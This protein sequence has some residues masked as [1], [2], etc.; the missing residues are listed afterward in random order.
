MPYPILDFDTVKHVFQ[1]LFD[2]HVGRV[3]IIENAEDE[4]ICIA[5]R[6]LIGHYS[7]K[8]W[9]LDPAA[10]AAGT[11]PAQPVQA[12]VV[13]GGTDPEGLIGK[14]PGALR[15]LNA[16][17]PIVYL[18]GTAIDPATLSGS[19]ELLYS[20]DHQELSGSVQVRGSADLC[21][22]LTE[23]F[24]AEPASATLGVF[25][26]D[27]SQH[28]TQGLSLGDPLA[29]CPNA[30]FYVALASTF[31]TI[32]TDRWR[33]ALAGLFAGRKVILLPDQSGE[34]Q[35]VYDRWLRGQ[36]C[37]WQDHLEIDDYDPRALQRAMLRWF[38]AGHPNRT[39]RSARPQRVAGCRVWPV[40]DAAEIETVQG[41]RYPASYSVY[42][43]WELCDGERTVL[44]I[45]ATVIDHVPG[46][47][48]ALAADVDQGLQ[49][50]LGLKMIALAWPSPAIVGP[51]RLVPFQDAPVVIDVQARARENDTIR[52]S[53]AL[54]DPVRGPSTLWYEVPASWDHALIQRAD[55]FLLAA[56]YV[57]MV[58]KRRLIVQG[59]PVSE[60]LL[61][62]LQ[63]FQQAWCSRYPQYGVVPIDAATCSDQYDAGQPAISCYSGG[64][65]SSFTL[66]QHSTGDEG[67][68]RPL[69]AAMLAL[70]L[71]IPAQD[72][73]GFAPLV[74]MAQQR[75]QE[76]SL[77]LIIVRTNIRTTCS[78][79]QYFHAPHIASCL[80]L[81]GGAFASGLIP[82]SF[83][84]RDTVIEG[85]NPVTDPL[86]GSRSFAI[87]HHGAAYNRLEKVQRLLQWP[88]AANRIRVCWRLPR[89]QENC[90]TC[91]KCLQTAMLFRACGFDPD[92]LSHVR[93]ADIDEHVRHVWLR[94]PGLFES[95]IAAAARYDVKPPWL[96]SLKARL[97]VKASDR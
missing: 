26:R 78:H 20:I 81:F 82:S 77:P 72:R 33:F 38:V 49:F 84:Y 60:S 41:Q 44:D 51:T 37:E 15:R 24:P 19:R 57:A 4:M 40:H 11:A 10:L 2:L 92:S 88:E 62:N 13:C 52:W 58:N 56:L 86:L 69:G 5:V 22:T 3:E 87:H 16:E 64:V 63:E 70:G 12:F 17:C 29:L 39:K 28:D 18:A 9:A 76:K 75:L 53:A 61:W 66:L 89:R 30:Y 32:V 1:P 6:H 90:G 31:A 43:I 96:E 59:A 55:P 74:A 46:P 48:P 8:G 7:I 94:G 95:V 91:W 97:T 47:V 25:L 93:D 54:T 68:A 42:L 50:L 45:I 21:L 35:E 73:E 83:T 85:S 67:R 36:G 80:T 79:Y 71:D 14:V 23:F 65:D 27:G 34:N